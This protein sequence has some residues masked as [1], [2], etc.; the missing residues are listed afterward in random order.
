VHDDVDL[1]SDGELGGLAHLEPPRPER[2]VPGETALGAP[3][4]AAAEV[5][6]VEVEGH[7]VVVED[8]FAPDDHQPPDLDLQPSPAPAP[9]ELRDV[10]PAGAEGRRGEGV[11]AQ[12]QPLDAHA[13]EDQAIAAQR[14]EA[15]ADTGGRDLEEGRRVGDGPSTAA[16]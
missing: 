10:V 8:E 6:Q 16:R 1:G 9:A 7:P 4:E 12:A 13:G 5:G 15:R 2:D 14:G 11:D 3:G